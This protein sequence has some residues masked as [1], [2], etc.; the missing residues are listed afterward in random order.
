MAKSRIYLNSLLLLFLSACITRSSIMTMPTYQSISVGEPL[1]EIKAKAGI[2]YAVQS[3][4]NGVEEYEYI[5]R[6]PLGT[7]VVEEHHYY[8]L[9]KNGVIIGKYMNQETPPAFD[10]IDDEDPND[11]EQ[12]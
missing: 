5:E 12:Q 9:I 7:E 4:G 10:L 8:L 11:M 3:K 1:T 2:P 6:I